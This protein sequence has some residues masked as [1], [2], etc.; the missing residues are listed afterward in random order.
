MAMT[1]ERVE[2]L[3]V[4]WREARQQGKPP[5]PEDLCAESPE[6]LDAVRE[7]IEAVL[8]M[9]GFLG[10]SQ[11]SEK[12][13]NEGIITRSLAE[14]D[15]TTGFPGG[16]RVDDEI[17][18]ELGRGGMGVVIGR[19]RI[20]KV[21]GE[22]GF[23]RVYLGHDN[24]LERQVAI[25]VPHFRRTSRTEMAD[26][27]LREARMLARLDHSNIV[28]VY[29]IGQAG[30]F[31]YVVSKYIEG[32][33][34][35]VLTSHGLPPFIESAK[36]AATIADAV[37]YAHHKGV[38]HRDIKPS[39]ILIDRSN[40]PYLADFGLALRDEDIGTGPH[41]AG[42]PAYMSP[43]Q[44]RGTGHLVDGRSDIFSLGVVLYELLTGRH[45]FRNDSWSKTLQQI[46]EV[47]AKPPR[48]LDD[49]IP[50]AL[51]R[52][53]LRALA[54]DLERRYTT[55]KDLADDLRRFL[56]AN[57]V[58]DRQLGE[59]LSH[60]HL[61]RLATQLEQAAD[62]KSLLI[63]VGFFRARLK[64][65][66]RPTAPIYCGCASARLSAHFEGAESAT[67]PEFRSLP[68]NSDAQVE[69]GIGDEPSLRLD[70]HSPATMLQGRARVAFPQIVLKQEQLRVAVKLEPEWFHVETPSGGTLDSAAQVVV[71]S[72]LRR[73]LRRMMKRFTF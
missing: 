37:H 61:F 34:L 48:M 40:R 33:N 22:G 38:V 19:Y 65:V 39:N 12:P 1:E 18:G 27:F 15:R 56:I 5:S 47:E 62:Q 44:A 41:L 68:K 63:D 13:N 71:D 21:L 7:Q 67:D 20:E 9:E 49:T 60:Q 14:P 26:T 35:A 73:L 30:G 70:A 16:G 4:R 31:C 72:V 8:Y 2:E 51:E 54:K 11:D 69:F 64:S 52:I 17:L 53:C 59:A 6:L 55:A 29:D 57:G 25:K 43:E 10:G 45:P 46:L 66:G 23:G 32:S 58:H 42:T 28:P 24:E 50:E 36:L 3:L